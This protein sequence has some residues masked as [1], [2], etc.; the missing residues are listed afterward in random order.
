MKV[1]MLLDKSGSM[2]SHWNEAVGSINAYVEGLKPRTEVYLA[3]FDSLGYNVV[4]ETTAKDWTKVETS[5]ITTGGMTPLYDAFGKLATK[6]ETDNIKKS[7]VVVMTD[8]F[9]NASKEYKQADVKA[10]ITEFEGKSWPVVFLGANFDAVTKSGASIGTDYGS[11]YTMDSAHMVAGMA[12]M[13]ANTNSYFK[14]KSRDALRIDEKTRKKL[15][16]N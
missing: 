12:Q 7:V 4:R 1:F 8:G 13:S 14:T 16:G 15:S 9:E 10:K 3:A 6:T 11:T 5:E 2:A